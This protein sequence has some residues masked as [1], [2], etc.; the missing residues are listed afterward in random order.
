MIKNIT[1]TVSNLM[2]PN[3]S[4]SQDRGALTDRVM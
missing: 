2:L 1:K 3:V 4:N